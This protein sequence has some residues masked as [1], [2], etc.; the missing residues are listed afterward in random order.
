LLILAILDT[1]ECKLDTY[2]SQVV[3]GLPRLTY[4]CKL[5]TQIFRFHVA[6]FSHNTRPIPPPSSSCQK[7]RGDL[8]AP[9]LPCLPLQPCCKDRHWHGRCHCCY[10]CRLP[11]FVD[12]CL[13]PQFLLLSAIAIA[14]VAA[15]ATAETAS[16]AVAISIRPHQ[17]CNCPFRPCTCPLRRPPASLPSPSLTSLPSPCV[18]GHN[19]W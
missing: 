18:I 8:N 6:N 17:R 7:E 4:K 1:Y 11:Q 12:C 16:A 2:K 10:C 5:Y 13:P 3:G 14:I 9:L 15:A 19:I